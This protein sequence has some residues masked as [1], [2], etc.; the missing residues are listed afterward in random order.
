M[1]STPV[2]S[3]GCKCKPWFTDSAAARTKTCRPFNLEQVTEV[4]ARAVHGF[5]VPRKSKAL[6][7]G[8]DVVDSQCQR[9]ILSLLFF[10]PP[11]LL[12][13]PCAFQADMCQKCRAELW[14]Q[15]RGVLLRHRGCQGPHGWGSPGTGANPPGLFQS[16]G[17]AHLPPAFTGW[18]KIKMWDQFKHL[19]KSSEQKLNVFLNP[20]CNNSGCPCNKR[21]I[22]RFQGTSMCMKRHPFNIFLMH[23]LCHSFPHFPGGP[24]ARWNYLKRDEIKCATDG[25]KD[26]LEDFFFVKQEIKKKKICS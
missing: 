6:V 23:L 1:F 4:Q 17:A 19:F 15:D 2:A 5:C 24:L 10:V 20:Y 12:P 25:Y 26:S 13:S 18:R 16:C 14:L 11:F 7:L 3:L 8:W 9:K 21:Q 22:I